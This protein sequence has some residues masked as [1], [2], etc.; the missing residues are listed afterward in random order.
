MYEKR[1]IAV[2]DAICQFFQ[3]H[4]TMSLEEFEEILSKILPKIIE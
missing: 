2:V 1:V 3:K 4:E